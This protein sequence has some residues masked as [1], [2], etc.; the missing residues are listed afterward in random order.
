MRTHTGEKLL[1]KRQS[2]AAHEDAHE[3]KAVQV[4]LMRVQ[5]HCKQ[6]SQE[7]HQDTYGRKAFQVLHVR[8][9]VQ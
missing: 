2:P 4:F 6:P 1:F 9:Q 7:P 8:L 3:R 5:V